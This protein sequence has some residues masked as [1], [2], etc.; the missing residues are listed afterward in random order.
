MPK[1]RWR[2]AA[3][4]QTLSDEALLAETLL[5]PGISVLQSNPGRLRKSL[6]QRLRKWIKDLPP[7]EAYR[8]RIGDLPVVHELAV[9]VPPVK[10]DSLRTSTVM[11]KLHYVQW[12][13]GKDAVIA[14]FPALQIEV[15]AADEEAL[16]EQLLPQVRSALSRQKNAASLRK[17]VLLHHRRQLQVRPM[18]LN[19]RIP[20]LKQAAVKEEASQAKA[21]SVLKQVAFD[22]TKPWT[23]DEQERTYD[24]S[25]EVARLGELLGGALPRSVLLVGKSGAGKTAIVRELARQRQQLGLGARP[26]WSTSGSRIVAGMTGFGM[27]QERCQKLLKETAKT[28]AIVHLDHL[29]ELI[30]VGKGGGNQQGIA[31][32]LAPSIARGSLLAI[33]ECTPQ[34]LAVIEREDPQLLEA[35]VQLEISESSPEQTRSIL[36]QVAGSGSEPTAQV[37]EPAALDVLDRLHRRYAAYSAPPGRPLRFLRNLLEDRRARHTITASDVTQAFSQE[38]GL[39]LFMLDDRVPLDVDATRDWFRRRVIGQPQPVDLVVD[40]ISS[41][42]AGLAR[43]GKPIASLLFIGPTGVGKTEMAKSLAEFLYQDP[44]RMIRFDM[45]EYALPHAIE[46][47]IGGTLTTEGLLTQK[48]RDQPFMVVLLDEFEKAHP[49]FFDVLLQVLGEGRL[50]DGAGRVA[51]FTS[52]VVIMTSNLGADTF[53]QANVGFA[54]EQALQHHAERHFEQA[55]KA[56]LRPEMFNRLDCIVPFAPLD[57]ATIVAIAQ[58]ELDRVMLRDGIRLRGVNLQIAPEVIQHLAANGYDPRYG[59]RPLKR[60]IER[61]LVAPLAEE[62]TRY[63]SDVII[64]STVGVSGGQLTMDISARPARSKDSPTDANTITLLNS[65]VELRRQ[66]QALQR[67][68][69]IL[70]ARNELQRIRQAERQERKRAKKRGK[71]VKFQFTPQQ[72]RALKHVDLLDRV[73]QLMLDVNALEETAL[74]DLYA[75]RKVDTAGIQEAR[76]LLDL[77][78]QSLLFDL[79]QQQDGRPKVM[80]LVITGEDLEQVCNLGMAYELLC[81]E[82]EIGVQRNWL[83]FYRPELDQW[84]GAAPPSGQTDLPVLRLLYRRKDN[85]QQE[86]LVDVYEVGEAGLAIPPANCIGLALQ[87]KGPRG[88]AL[89]ETESGAHS[90]EFPNN[91][92]SICYVDAAPLPLIAYEPAPNIGR[93]GAHH[94]ARVR[95]RYLHGKKLCL[96]SALQQAIALNPKRLDLAIAT[97][98]ERY[99]A[100][101]TWSLLET[102]N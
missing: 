27:W 91:R 8:C 56:Y 60:A 81:R 53:R 39:P 64:E 54:G 89:L 43:G 9:E 88:V 82:R 71:A 70:Q 17:L 69:V 41:V 51:D 16:L 1:L 86:K 58:R 38:T 55:V 52:T 44:G 61:E 4:V 48:V 67:S 7:G 45:S 85:S 80:T 65:V 25:A 97:L 32:L 31:S 63:V 40:L 26:L 102:W 79:Y 34:Q 94:D 76:G 19:V 18:H 73:D 62:L 99:L 15:L 3:L 47:L 30:E 75:G 93:V 100:N 84:A 59:A 37:I 21:V 23:K 46:R 98:V 78:L 50:T 66:T 20:T 68:G 90:F 57:Q 12:Q 2:L 87:V 11:L 77:E 36:Q 83:K 24:R 96:D 72:A 22:L 5:F 14:Y 35:F 33:A 95:R 49:L 13:H 10:D 92:Q 74:L 28:R 101:R 29:V 6:G 42:K